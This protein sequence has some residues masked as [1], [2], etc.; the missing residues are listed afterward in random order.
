MPNT[1]QYLSVV[2]VSP[3]INWDSEV[4]TTP[5]IRVRFNIPVN[6]SFV[7]TDV[8]LNKYVI[9]VK[10]DSDETV[11]VTF[12]EWDASLRVL[13]F[14][15]ESPLTPG[16]LYQVTLRKE[17][18]SVAGRKM[19]ENRTWS[20]QVSLG[21]LSVPE[22]RSPADATA[23]TTN[24]TLSWDGV[25]GAAATG[26]IY[27]DVQLHRDW[28]FLSPLT[29][30]TTVT[31]SGSG[32]THTATIGT[33][34][35][36]QRGYFWRVRA[37][38]SSTSGDWS[39][40][41]TFWLGD[42]AVVSPEPTQTYQPE[43]AFRAGNIY[44]EEGYTQLTDWPTIRASFTQAISGASVTSSTFYVWKTPVHGY[45]A[46]SGTT[47]AG[48]AT[49]LDTEIDFS[50]T[51]DLTP[52][53]RYRLV[54]TTAVRSVSG[55]TLPEVAQ[56][57]FTSY[58]L[59][60]Y[61]G[62]VSCRS[63]LG[64]FIDDIGDDELSF[65]IWKAS[66]YVNELLYTR[67]HRVRPYATFTDLVNYRPPHDTTWGMMRIAELQAAITLLEGHYFD[68]AKDAGQRVGLATFQYE[69]SVELLAEMRARIKDLR[70]ELKE[71]LATFLS[72]TTV[73]RTLIQGQM[74]HPDLPI[75]QDWSYDQIKRSQP[76]RRRYLTP[77]HPN[78]DP[79]SRRHNLDD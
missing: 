62:V 77:D 21:D 16:A 72:G 57:Y 25:T 56:T 9:L 44:P 47:V 69:V 14:N 5:D 2:H 75:A 19:P 54:V 50:P 8:E 10:L 23:W 27:Y 13:T 26:T 42:S 36:S 43:L 22:L 3:R 1:A 66:L 17:L 35:T 71:L 28:Q 30:S 76:I 74:W 7:S 61:G 11:P 34:L 40:A 20:F 37:R 48:T 46:T 18:E 39:E 63:L 55:E 6:E 64:G 60:F 31:A 78:G 41:A 65:H 29:W 79:I 12:V 15:P 68:L 38:T 45:P 4:G 51:E 53:T 33:T 52:N 32:G 70:T 73:P 58:Y 67:V 49:V 24:P 59:P